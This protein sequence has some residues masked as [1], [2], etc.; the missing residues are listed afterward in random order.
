[1]NERIKNSTLRVESIN[2]RVVDFVLRVSGTIGGVCLFHISAGR[3]DL[4]LF[5]H[6][7]HTLFTLFSHSF[8]TL[9][10]VFSQS[11]HS[12]FTVFS[13]SFHSLFTVF[14]QSFHSLF[15]VFSQSFRTLEYNR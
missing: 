10:T 2:V 12:L 6:S 11:F 4:A 14:S 8:H 7:L 13:Q 1:M 9:F 15:T 3:L 5:S